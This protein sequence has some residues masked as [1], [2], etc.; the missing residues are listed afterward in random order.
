MTFESL[1]ITGRDGKRYE[2]G[3]PMHVHDG[4]VHLGTVDP[5]RVSRDGTEVHIERFLPSRF[6]KEKKRN[7]GPLVLLEVTAYLAE[8][9]HGI[10]TVSYSLSR[11]IEMHGDGMKVAS[12]RSALLQDIGAEGVTITPRPDHETPG[13]FVVEGVWAYN[14]RNL[15]S[16]GECLARER[17]IYRQWEAPA[18]HA[19]AIPA[20]RDRLRQLLV[21]GAGETGMRGDDGAD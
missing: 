11:E 5:V 16:L 10:Q 15:A 9:F 21:R 19:T 12:A 4:S 7:F 2:L 3:E 14:E 13:N 8:H 20:L 1:R 17:E 6:V 18:S